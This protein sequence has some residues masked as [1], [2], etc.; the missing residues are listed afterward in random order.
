MVRRVRQGQGSAADIVNLR[1]A[2]QSALEGPPQPM[3]APPAPPASVVS[4]QSA[5]T[6]A[7]N[8]TATGRWGTSAPALENSAHALDSDSSERWADWSDTASALDAT[9]Q[10]GDSISVVAGDQEPM[11]KFRRGGRQGN[12]G[13]L[14]NSKQERMAYFKEV[15]DAKAQ[16]RPVPPMPLLTPP[17]PEPPAPPVQK[18]MPEP[19]RSPSAH[20]LAG[21]RALGASAKTSARALGSGLA[22]VPE[23]APRTWV[24]LSRTTGSQY[25]TDVEPSSADIVLWSGRGWDLQL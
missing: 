2:L 12:G 16:G 7:S 6:S 21:A 24:Y 3:P 5:I 15:A 17:K 4:V 18:S 14:F 20:A 19:W 23:E 11:P 25:W 9:V 10:P 13:R 1:E 8:I 22:S